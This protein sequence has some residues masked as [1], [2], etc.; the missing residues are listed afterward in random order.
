MVT[1]ES[2]FLETDSAQESTMWGIYLGISLGPTVEHME[3]K[4][5]YNIVPFPPLPVT[6]GSSRDLWLCR[7]S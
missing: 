7:A 1:S 3:K 6:R 5:K 2:A 4:L